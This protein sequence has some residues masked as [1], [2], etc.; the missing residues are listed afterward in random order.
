MSVP[1]VLLLL[2]LAAVPASVLVDGPAELAVS[3]VGV[4]LAL[5]MSARLIRPGEGGFLA[6][7]CQPWALVAAIPALIMVIQVL[8]LPPLAHPIWKDAAEALG[9]SLAGS[10]SVDPGITLIALTRY[11]F[12]IG[13]VWLTMAVT[14]DRQRA[15]KILFALVGVS[16]ATVAST[17]IATRVKDGSVLGLGIAL[18]SGTASAGNG[19]AALGLILS[20]AAAVHAAEHFETRRGPHRADLRQAGLS[21]GLGAAAFAACSLVMLVAP[22]SLVFAA[23]CGSGSSPRFSW[24]A[25]SAPARESRLP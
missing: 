21:I 14:I 3:A 7:A 2:L 19:V 11:L 22:A 4:A 12:I 17:A 6:K 18:S 20:A 13:L 10:I 9:T 25:V 16:V 24:R 15:Q 5:A 1:F 8:P 23:G